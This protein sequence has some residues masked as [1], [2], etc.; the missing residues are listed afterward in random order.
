MLSSRGTNLNADSSPLK[1]AYGEKGGI[2]T[3]EPSRERPFIDA[4]NEEDSSS[5]EMPRNVQTVLPLKTLGDQ[6]GYET[7]YIS[8]PRDPSAVATESRNGGADTLSPVPSSRLVAA[9]TGSRN[10]KENF[11]RDSFLGLESPFNSRPGSRA[12]SPSFSS[13]GPTKRPR[14]HVKS[15]TLSTD[16]GAHSQIPVAS[17]DNAASTALQTKSQVINHSRTASI[18]TM[19]TMTADQINLQDWFVPPKTLARS[20]GSND[21]LQNEHPSFYFNV[22]DAVSTPARQIRHNTSIYTGDSLDLDGNSV[23][24][25]PAPAI[26]PKCPP[27]RRRKTIM[28]APDDSLFS[29]IL[30]FSAY[31][32]D[33]ESPTRI[34]KSRGPSLL[35]DGLS[36]D[37]AN[38][39]HHSEPIAAGLGSAF[40][41]GPAASLGLE[42]LNAGLSAVRQVHGIRSPNGRGL[43]PL[44]ASMEI[45]SKISFV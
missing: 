13:Q 4:A 8:S 43:V 38:E 1:N 17:P 25:G 41:P 19:P 33:E 22:P 7:P 2:N 35:L 14:L 15:R 23:I 26:G 40:S 34:R 44:F 42:T 28:Q 10:L 21:A 16:I 11:S 18:P 6:G 29:S 30:D 5:P 37:H 20:P 39:L 36:Q 12:A 31:I 24:G 27:R 45:S 32:T 3:A 9:R